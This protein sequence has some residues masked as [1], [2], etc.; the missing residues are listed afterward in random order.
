MNDI[1]RTINKDEPTS[2]PAMSNPGG[3]TISRPPIID[4]TTLNPVQRRVY[5]AI[6]SGPRGVVEGPLRLWLLSPG[7]AERAQELGAF[8][9]YNT[10]LAPRLSELAILVTGAF[11][12][13][14]FEWVAHCP[15]AIS[16]GLSADIAEAIRKDEEPTFEQEDEAAVFALARELHQTR[17]LSDAT[18]ERAIRLLGL[19]AVVELVGIL[20]Y[21]TLVS[22]TI[23]AF[24]IPAPSGAADPFAQAE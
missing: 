10:K 3:T 12:K 16:A 15:A 6:L 24:E 4:E 11:W 14:G 19:E 13:A 22:M 7:L 23:N 21:Y 17:R 5:D 2:S 20:G 1:Y 18:Y 9:R 8:C